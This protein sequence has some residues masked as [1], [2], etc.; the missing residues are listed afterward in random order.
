MK[1]ILEFN[2]EDEMDKIKFDDTL[3]ATDLRVAIE[4]FYEECLRPLRKYGVMNGEP[5]DKLDVYDVIDH[6]IGAYNEHV[7]ERL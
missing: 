5:I 2:L 6:I 7:G 3:G 4:N 1:V